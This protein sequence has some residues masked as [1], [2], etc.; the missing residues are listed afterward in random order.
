MRQLTFTV[1]SVVQVLFKE[2]QIVN[3]S[4]LARHCDMYSK[5]CYES[6]HCIVA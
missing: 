6:Q 1:L 3:L 5:V 4:Y 2:L